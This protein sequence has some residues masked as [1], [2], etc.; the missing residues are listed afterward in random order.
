MRFDWTDE[1]LETAKTLWLGGKSASEVAATFGSACTRQMII[2]QA[3]RR[4]WERKITAKIGHPQTIWTDK[5]VADLRALVD[6]RLSRPNIAERMGMSYDQ[7]VSKIRRLGLDA[8]DARRYAGQT[9]RA[10]ER[11]NRLREMGKAGAPASAES[12]SPDPNVTGLTTLEIPSRGAC[13]WPLS[14][15]GAVMIMCGCS[16]G[17]R[18]Y[19]ASHMARAYVPSM[20]SPARAR[21][22]L[23]RSV[24]RYV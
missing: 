12:E 13:R 6:E 11:S 2:G 4:G 22:S 23:E 15:A 7:I 18:V 21:R 3:Y 10:A 1:R 24:G 17:D 16:C 20:K 5:M 19:C 8:H 9:V 14:G